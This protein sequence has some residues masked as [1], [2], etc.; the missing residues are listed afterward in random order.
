[1]KIKGYVLTGIA[2]FSLGV[3]IQTT[4]AQAATWHSLSIP[5]VLQGHWYSKYDHS[6]GVYI[7]RHYIHYTGEK[8]TKV[9]WRYAGNH[10]YKFS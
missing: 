3:T 7:Y 2:V 4:S 10:F 1:M 9:K 6:Q 5:T 8:S